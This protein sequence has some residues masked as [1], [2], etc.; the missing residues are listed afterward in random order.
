MHLILMVPVNLVLMLLVLADWWI[1]VSNSRLQVLYVDWWLLMLLL[2]KHGNARKVMMTWIL[3]FTEVRLEIC[4]KSWSYCFN[5]SRIRKS[6]KKFIS[7]HKPNFQVE[8]SHV[9]SEDIQNEDNLGNLSIFCLS[10][11]FCCISSQNM[12]LLVISLFNYC[13]KNV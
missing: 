8:I 2:L 3:V 6:I 11:F 10:Y 4:W 7:I 13:F 12:Y 9:F 5:G 1:I